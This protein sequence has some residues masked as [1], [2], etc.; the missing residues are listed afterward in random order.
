MKPAAA[1]ALIPKSDGV[2]LMTQSPAAIRSFLSPEQIRERVIALAKQIDADYSGRELVAIG[3]LQGSYV[4]FSDLVREMK[5]PL[6]CEF[7]ALSTYPTFARP[8]DTQSPSPTREEL[9]SAAS[10]EVKIL[11]DIEEPLAGKNLLLIEDLVDTGLT[12]EFLRRTLEAR[13]PASLKTCSLLVRKQRPAQ[14]VPIDYVGFEI[15]DA[16]V[17]GYGIDHEGAFR[18]LPYIG[19]M[20]GGSI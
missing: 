3:V 15:E 11:L 8:T 16:F 18:E 5:T 4:F 7:L 20:E 19:R 1:V 17:V 13:K 10:G 2:F 14:A 12:L 9:A 6:S